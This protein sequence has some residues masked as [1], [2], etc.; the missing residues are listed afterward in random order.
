MSRLL[1]RRLRT[2][3]ARRR[4]TALLCL[5]LTGWWTASASA[6]LD[7]LLFVKRVPPTV[8]IVVDTSLRMMEDGSGNYY[9]P[10]E[11]TTASDPVVSTALGVSGAPRYRRIYRNLQYESVVDAS[12]KFEATDIT[13]RR[14][15]RAR[16][17]QFLQQHPVGDGES[18]YQ[19]GGRRERR[20]RVSLGITQAAPDD[21]G[22]AGIAELRQTRSRDRQ[23]DPGT[24][25]GQQP[26]QC[27]FRR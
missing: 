21:A 13:A 14:Q 23:R 18:R 12:S 15:H 4:A 19:A 17:L 26:V 1:R 7:P 22:L 11:Y 20:C 25:V 2:P 9:D 3:H 8:I 27:R 5:A 6:Q 16:L 10:V 24:A